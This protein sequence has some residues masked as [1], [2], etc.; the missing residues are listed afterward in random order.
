LFTKIEDSD[1][2]YEKI[3]RKLLKDDFDSVVG[4]SINDYT[5]D[6]VNRFLENQG[7]C[8]DYYFNVKVDDE[9]EFTSIL[10]LL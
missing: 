4:E 9:L 8:V 3:I 7:R 1:F 2:A 5:Y 6:E 10:E